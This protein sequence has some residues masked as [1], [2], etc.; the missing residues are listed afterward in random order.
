MVKKDLASTLKDLTLLIDDE[1]FV[2]LVTNLQKDSNDSV[3]IPIMDALVALKSHP[4]V[5]KYTDFIIGSLVKL[6]TDESWRVRLTVADKIHEILAFNNLNPNLKSTAVELYAKMF[7]DTEGETRNVCCQ[8]LEV[9]AEKIGK[10]DSIDKVLAQLKKL[11]KDNV[12]YV[13]AALASTILRICPL[14]GKN[15]TN[16]YVFPVFLNLIKDE[17]HDIRMTLI[18]TL[19]RLHEVINIDIFVQSIIPSII[20][21]ANNKAWRIRIQITESIPVLARILVKFVY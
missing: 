8:K 9:I 3:R 5:Q 1:L 11:E 19:D 2:Y 14:I 18:K 10:E 12:S 6:S 20:E 15:K 7:D 13:R 17:S 16:E 21:I 4:Q